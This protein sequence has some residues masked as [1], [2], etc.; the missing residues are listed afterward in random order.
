MD[1]SSQPLRIVIVGGVA[2]G[3]TAAARARRTNAQA[4]II[5]L[6]MGAAVS[7][8]NCGLPYH[9][10][11]EITDRKKLLVATPEL[12]QKRFQVDV[13][14]QSE[15]TAID[16]AACTV[17]VQNLQTQQTYQLRYD[18]LILATGS[19]PLHP[20]FWAVKVRNVFQLWNLEDLDGLLALI[21]ECK[22]QS[23]AVVGASYIGLEVVE[24]LHRLGIKLS[25]IERN[26]HVLKPLDAD[27]AAPIARELESQGVQLY[28][29]QRVE[30]MITEG[31]RAIALQLQDGQQVECELVIVGIGV[32][33]RV[34]LAQAAGLA[35]GKQG[36][37]TV[38]QWMQTSD[39]LIYA[40]GDMTELPHGVLPAPQR[41]PL[42]GSANR[43][44]RI[45]GAHAAA[46]QT[47]AMGAV[48]GTAI[49]RVF[50]LV[51]ATTGVSEQACQANG[52]D[53]RVAIIQAADHATYYPGA[54]EMTIKILYAP[55]SGR[56]LGAQIVGQTGVD[57]RIDILATTLHFQGTVHDLAQLDLAYAPPF[58]SAK[59]PVNLIAFVA[60]NDLANQ[61]TLLPTDAS[62]AGWQV[63]D[64]RTATEV[65]NLPC[66][67]ATHIP[68]DELPL[69][70]QEL[71]P[72]QPTVVVCHS[73]KRAHIGACWLKG[74]GFSQVRNLTGGMAMRRHVLPSQ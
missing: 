15:V 41:I 27:M 34:E 22:P 24:Q 68:I 32:R 53:Y 45:A 55:N 4:E 72:N 28:L 16:R 33:P 23:A 62:L 31:D 21:R 39:P 57:K 56:L 47:P 19:E 63:I 7:F 44:G 58:G 35:I 69:R 40:V 37:V 14:T 3:A 42:A 29:N 30:K 38:N 74:H 6:E 67:G 10:G 54:R 9:L 36:G 11:G 65:S 71:D 13:R 8:A 12:F 70:W 26:P 46:G 64:V 51:A 5:L 1:S 17:T 18:R 66:A 60:E 59:D 48:L 73:G 2:G 43:G 50:N 61:P 20:D 25:L 49:V 52:I